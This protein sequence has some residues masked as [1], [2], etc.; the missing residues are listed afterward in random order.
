MGRRRGAQELGA[1]KLVIGF[2]QRTRLA[3]LLQVQEL[4][5]DRGLNLG[6]RMTA[7]GDTAAQEQEAEE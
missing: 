6:G 4:L 1:L 5:A 7:N 2:G 3:G